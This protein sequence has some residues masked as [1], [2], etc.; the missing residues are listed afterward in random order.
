MVDIYKSSGRKPEIPPEI[1]QA[2]IKEL[3]EKEGFSSYKEIPTW[4]Y[5][6]HDLDVKYK[7]VHDTVR[8]RLKAKLKVPRCSNV[9]KD[10]EAEAEF[11][12]KNSRN[13]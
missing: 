7:V 6:V 9:K 3:N 8:Y 11:K 1:Q 2:L 4:L 5:T 13:N 10:A 12:K